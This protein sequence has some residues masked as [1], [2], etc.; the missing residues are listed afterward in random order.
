MTNN[1]RGEV[2]TVVIVVM[3]SVGLA[4]GVLL[5]NWNPFYK[6]MGKEPPTKELAELQVKLDATAAEAKAKEAELIKANAQERA[7]LEKQ[8]QSAQGDALGAGEAIKRVPIEHQTTEVKFAGKMVQR[9]SLKLARA[10]GALPLDQQEAMIELVAQALSEKQG[11]VDEALRKLAERDA[12]FTIVSKERDTLVQNTIPKLE[13]EKES[14]ETQKAELAAKVKEKT[15]EVVVWADKKVEADAQ[16]HSFSGA[17][18]NLW[19]WIKV[20]A[21][22]IV[23]GYLFLAFILPAIVTE[24]KSGPL[25]NFLRNLSGLL[26]NPVH[27]ANAKKKIA[28]L[29]N[30]VVASRAPFPK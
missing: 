1:N 8:V 13:K 27:H 5:G 23:G 6:L 28:V 25:K 20:G 16:A 4:S 26:L 21:A 30:E 3:F 15:D 17:L 9:V 22:V 14:V 10:I 11:E 19:F 12:A 7:D 18:E 24:M 2:T 29:K